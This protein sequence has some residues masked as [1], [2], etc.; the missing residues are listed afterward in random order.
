M[1]LVATTTAPTW[2][3]PLR[4]A[5][6]EIETRRSSVDIM[7]RRLDSILID[8]DPKEEVTPED[9]AVAEVAQLSPE[10]YEKREKM[11][12]ESKDERG[13]RPYQ[14]S[15]RP[16]YTWPE[17][18]RYT[19]PFK[20]DEA[21]AEY[22]AEIKRRLGPRPAPKGKAPWAGPKPKLSQRDVPE[23]TQ[24]L[25]RKQGRLPGLSLQ[26]DWIDCVRMLLRCRITTWQSEIIVL[27]KVV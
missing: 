13:A 22:E 24:Q 10:K 9:D 23:K 6:A 4:E 11:L 19:K 27:M 5:K 7:K 3:C 8:L 1:G 20:R 17:V 14:G 2:R 12:V 15:T 21:I 18:W 25:L 26:N 16:P